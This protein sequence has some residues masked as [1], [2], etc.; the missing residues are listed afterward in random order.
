MREKL[1]GKKKQEKKR[2]KYETIY[3][4][5]PKNYINIWV[6]L[7]WN[8]VADT[9]DSSNRDTIKIPLPQYWTRKLQNTKDWEITLKNIDYLTY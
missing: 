4:K 7:L 8:L 9:N 1:F 3:I 2:E 6:T 5:I